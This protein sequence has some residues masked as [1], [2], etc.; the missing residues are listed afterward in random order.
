[1]FPSADAWPEFIY[2]LLRRYAVHTILLAGCEFVYHMLPGID[3]DF[4]NIRVID[5]L[6]N[7]TGHIANNRKYAGVIDLNVVPSQALANTLID[8]YRETPGKVKIIPHGVAADVPTYRDRAEAFAAS[9][10]PARSSGKF[11]VSF[12]GRLSEEKSPCTFV[13][14]ARCLSSHPDIDFCMTGEGPERAAVLEMIARHRLG[15][16]IFAPGFVPDVR[17]LIA[18]SDVV[19]VPSRLDGM[20]L[21]VLESQMFGKPV[22]ASAVGSL[23]EMV[24][25]GITGYICQVGDVAAFCARIEELHADPALRRRLGERARAAALARYS[26]PRMVAAYVDAFEGPHASAAAADRREGSA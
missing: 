12:F 20:P 2:Y 26:T 14:I 23:P 4:P 11:I 13:E 8:K 19:V 15:E 6:F 24:N 16:R 3:R 18:C 21:I 10:L 5:Q 17:P 1:L 22:I 7:D 9:G 25:D